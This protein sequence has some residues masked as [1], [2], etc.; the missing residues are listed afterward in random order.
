MVILDLQQIF[1]STLLSSPANYK[2]IS[3]NFLRHMVI[4]CIRANRVKFKKEHSEF[5]IAC[6]SKDSWRKTFFPYYKHHRKSKREGLPINWEEVFRV[7]NLLTE[8]LRESF[9]YKIV[10]VPGAEADDIIASLVFEYAKDIDI[11][12]LSGDKDFVQLQNYTGV[13]QFDPIRKRWLTTD[14][15]LQFLK[16]HIYRG[17]KGDG[18]PNILSSDDSLIN[19]T[20][21]LSITKKRINRWNTVGFEGNFTL[22]RNF[23]RNRTLIDLTNVPKEIRENII[24][25]YKSAKVE[26]KIF[27]YFRTHK[28]N[29]LMENI[30]D[31]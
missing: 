26:S 30:S 20:R 31:F 2:E 27:D 13:K 15:P 21:C 8:E 14:K 12:I 4:N 22:E 10:K 16:E 19:G 5:V 28:L 7:F 29:N 17:D 1:F 6:D 24:Q 9:P 11:L 23:V 18:I 25:E 3:E